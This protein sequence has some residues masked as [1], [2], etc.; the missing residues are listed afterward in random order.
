MRNWVDKGMT[1]CTCIT[2][3]WTYAQKI[4]IS[5]Y[6]H[7]C[8]SNSAI[9]FFLPVAFFQQ[10]YLH[11]SVQKR[12]GSAVQD[13]VGALFR[14]ATIFLRLHSNYNMISLIQLSPCVNNSI[15]CNI[16]CASFLGGWYLKRQSTL[17]P[18]QTLRSLWHS[19]R[20]F[21]QVPSPK[22]LLSSPCPIWHSY[23]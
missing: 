21:A 5:V 23:F 1:F 7:A 6:V 16:L 19:G 15:P 9:T 22:Y 18:T 8:D 11:S 10:L 17:F 3:Y 14:K 13:T 2:T 4:Q 20:G 12:F